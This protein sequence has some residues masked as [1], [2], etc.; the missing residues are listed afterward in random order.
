MTLIFFSNLVITLT[1]TLN[2]TFTQTLIFI[3]TLNLAVPKSHSTLN[4]F[5]CVYYPYIDPNPE[6]DPETYLTPTIPLT[7]PSA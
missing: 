1:F 3:L 7:L 6:L 4:V 2:Q 5:Y